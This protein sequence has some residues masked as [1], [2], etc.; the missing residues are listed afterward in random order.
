METYD[1]IIVGAGSAGCVLANRLS[2]DPAVRVLLLEAGGRDNYHWIH[3]PVGYLYCIGNPRTDWMYRTGAEPGLGGRSL[4]Y[5]RGR[6]LGG[7]SS[8]NGMIYMR[9]QRQDYDQWAEIAGD[10]SWRWDQVLPVFKR[11]EDH[12]RG[13][14]EFHGV[15]GEWRVEAQRLRWDILDAFASAAEQEGIPRVADFNRGDNF[16]VGYFDVNQRR[17]W[18]W[19]TA[20]AFLRPVRERPNLQV[21]TGAHAE[22]LLFEGTRCVG[23]QVRRDGQSAS[24][25]AARE[26]VLA[27]GAVNTPQLLELSGIGEP[28]RLR[29]SGI[30]LRHALPGVGENLQDH[31]Q[32]RVILK[33]RGVKTLNR[34]ASTWWGKAGIGLEYLLNRSG[35]MSMAPSQLGA[36]AKSD[37][38]QARANLEFHVQPLSLGAFGEPLHGFDAFTAS[39]CNLRPVSRG[40]VH[41]QGADGSLPPA[42]TPNYLKEEQDLK[43]AADAIRLVR[44]ISA[45]PAL[46]RYQP[47]EWLP[48]PAYQS[49]AELREAAGKIGTTIFHP[50]G[51]CAMGRRADDGAVVDAR[52]RVHG[53]QGLRV[54]DASIMPTI[55]SGNT[56]SPTIMI[57]ERAAQMILED[58]VR[59]GAEARAAELVE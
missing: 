49:E 42:I 47:E 44:R 19:N 30:A 43:V 55:T 58:A 29:E 2:R 32:L 23:V 51:T 40:S 24:V 35:P 18:R 31:L 48:G 25:R 11:S 52:L 20:K 45:A 10:P 33:V 53:L 46:Q 59:V 22:R 4:I 21:M 36:F 41:A 57:A 13:A 8:I 6:V 9:G 54:A 37:P 28:A 12:H 34:V 7:C 27:A 1:Y 5:P 16:G 17:G 15:G 56:N 26:V 38:G 39:V 50:V 14:D 3:I